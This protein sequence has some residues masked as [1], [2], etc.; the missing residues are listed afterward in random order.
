[1]TLSFGSWQHEWGELWVPPVSQLQR[2][3]EEEGSWDD[4]QSW[5]TDCDGTRCA[6]GWTTGPGAHTRCMSTSS[7]R[8]SLTRNDSRVCCASTLCGGSESWGGTMTTVMN[9]YGVHGRRR[10][11]EAHLEGRWRYASNFNSIDN[12]TPVL[13]CCNVGG[14]LPCSP[15]FQSA[16]ARGNESTAHSRQHRGLAESGSWDSEDEEYL[17]YLERQVPGALN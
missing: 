16:V 15:G 6:H 11:A 13:Y 14:C 5:N 17:S 1:M 12:C 2:G 9:A 8:P 4:S 3:Y 7:G 10:A